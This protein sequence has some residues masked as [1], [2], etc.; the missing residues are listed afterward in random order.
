MIHA[1]YIYLIIG[2]FLGGLT[3]S[4]LEQTLVDYALV[5]FA[6]VLWPVFLIMCAVNNRRYK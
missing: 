1:I 6:F 3:L 2:A 5:L 4:M